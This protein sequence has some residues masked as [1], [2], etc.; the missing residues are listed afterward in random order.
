MQGVG[1]HCRPCRQGVSKQW[2]AAIIPWD[3]KSSL[4]AQARGGKKDRKKEEEEEEEKAARLVWGW[5]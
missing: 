3:R 2:K 5:R 1:L 4:V